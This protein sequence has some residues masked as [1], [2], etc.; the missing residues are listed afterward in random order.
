MHRHGLLLEQP[1]QVDLGRMLGVSPGS[2]VRSLEP[3]DLQ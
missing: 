1:D 2:N 3:G